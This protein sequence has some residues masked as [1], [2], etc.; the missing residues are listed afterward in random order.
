MKTQDENISCSVGQALSEPSSRDSPSC[1]MGS[2]SE[3]WLLVQMK[4]AVIEAVRE[5]REELRD[6]F[7]KIESER[8]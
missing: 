4:T 1:A 8:G 6:K 7:E 2:D 5:V 3:R